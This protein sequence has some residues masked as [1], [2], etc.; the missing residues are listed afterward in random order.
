MTQKHLALAVETSGRAGSLAL[1]S[2]RSVLIEHPFTGPLRHSA[3]LFPTLSHILARRGCRPADIKEIYVSAGPGSFTGIRIAITFA[4]TFSFACA[5]RVVAVD[6]LEI[7]ANNASD[8]AADT[9]SHVNRIATILD[10]K[11]GRFY[12]AV[13]RR[14]SHAWTRETEDCLMTSAEF[15]HRFGRA[16][17]IWLLGEG[18]LYY[19]DAFSAPAI[20]IMDEK[21]WPARAGKLYALAR[22]HA[23][24]GRFADPARLVPFYLRRPEISKKSRNR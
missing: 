10:A 20:K 12:V 1:G 7:I 11:R 8:F 17:P 6:T 3:E 13:F 23:E 2:G 4:K 14:T 22:K 19:R 21:Y 5:A 18:L 9:G 16:E 15:V 24:Q